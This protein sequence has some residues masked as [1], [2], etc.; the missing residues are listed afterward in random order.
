VLETLESAKAQSYRNIEL[1]I[2]DDHSTDDTCEVCRKW[3]EENK[4]RFVRTEFIEAQK[5]TGIPGNC[6][7]GLNV[8]QGE[9]IK[10]IAG[11]DV[12]MENCVET[13]V[14]FSIANNSYLATSAIEEF[15]EEG[16]PTRI[17]NST[18]LKQLAFFKKNNKDQ[19]K[20]YIRD[21]IFLNTPAFLIK[22][23]LF[24]NIG[25]FDESF[26]MLE[27]TPF[28]LRTLKAGYVVFYNQQV[29]VRYRTSPQAEN[30]VKGQSED[31][32]MCFKRYQR[33][34]L[35]IFN[36]VDI[37]VLYHWFLVNRTRNAKNKC[38]N[39]FYRLLLNF[40]SPIY[41]KGKRAN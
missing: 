25:G 20:F 40:T 1:V 18:L 9:W 32:F 30:R 19:F 26:R 21:S 23:D 14:S 24:N 6:N 7:R 37:C 17:S 11:D 41:I 8:A 12:L 22:K 15:C 5:N 39:V 29:T 4:I 31:M 35:N 36:I 28:V 16:L 34:Y 3:I 38:T 2:S 10:F 13:M 33:P 27:D